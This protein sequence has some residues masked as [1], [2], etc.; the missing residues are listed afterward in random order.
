MMT[1]FVDYVKSAWTVRGNE[2]ASVSSLDPAALSSQSA[3]VAPGILNVAT[4]WYTDGVMVSN[5][6]ESG[7]LTR[8]AY[9]A[10]RRETAR[11]DGRGN[12]TRTVHDG[13]GRVAATIDALSN[14]TAYDFDEIGN[15]RTSSE[16]GV[17]SAEYVANELNQYTIIT[18]QTSHTSQT[19]QTSF[20]ADGNQTLVKTA[21]GI[22]QVTYNGENRPI[23]WESNNQTIYKVLLVIKP[24]KDYHWYRQDDDGLWSHKRGDMS[25]D[26]GVVK[27]EQDARQR[28]YTAICGYLCFPTK[29][30]DTDGTK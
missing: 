13:L 28:G 2:T 5:A 23:R 3:T 4:N 24:G 8:C 16:C 6:T 30:I 7:V 17:M 9:D 14:T 11:I 12:V 18:S 22:W 27:P 29:G 20:D 21:T 15:R 1:S 26:I 19:F 10:L 25:I